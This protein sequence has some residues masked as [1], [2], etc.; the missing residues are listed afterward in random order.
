MDIREVELA[1][2]MTRAN[3]RFY[4]KEGLLTPERRPNGYRNY[5]QDDLETLKKIKLLRQLHLSVDTIRRLQ[6]GEEDLDSALFRAMEDMSA[7]EDDLKRAESVCRTIRSER[8][9]YA[10]LDAQPVSGCDQRAPGRP[11]RL[12]FPAAG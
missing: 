6:Q 11:V 3:I 5:S 7:Q 4:E 2:E 1:A 8:A 10:S 9:S 12:F